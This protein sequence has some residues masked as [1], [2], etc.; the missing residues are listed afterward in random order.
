MSIKCLDFLLIPNKYDHLNLFIYYTYMYVSQ[1][2][3]IIF[4]SIIQNEIWKSYFEKSNRQ[5]FWYKFFFSKK[6][7]KRGQE[8]VWF[9]ILMYGCRNQDLKLIGRPTDSRFI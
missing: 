8:E 5:V 9:K 7:C 3:K 6:M 4:K 2:L 1:I